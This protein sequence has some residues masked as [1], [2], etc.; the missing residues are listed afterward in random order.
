[1]SMTKEPYVYDKKSPMSMAKKPS[2]HGNKR[3]LCL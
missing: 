1:M 3:A 2:V